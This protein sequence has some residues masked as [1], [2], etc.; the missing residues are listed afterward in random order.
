MLS[1]ISGRCCRISSNASLVYAVTLTSE[2]AM[3]VAL[4]GS[5]VIIASHQRNRPGEAWQGVGSNCLL[6]PRAL[7]HRRELSNRAS[8][9]RTLTGDG[10]SRTNGATR[11]R[12]ARALRSFVRERLKTV[13]PPSAPQCVCSISAALFCSRR[14]RSSSSQE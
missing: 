13:L 2:R 7:Q 14:D 6:R 5:P 11:S 9:P 4:R 8:V 12:V 10:S 1:A 3:T